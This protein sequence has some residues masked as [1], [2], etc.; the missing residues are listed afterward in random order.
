MRYVEFES[1]L[2]PT[3]GF[4]LV[5][6]N[7]PKTRHYVVRF[8]HREARAIIGHGSEFGFLP[9]AVMLLALLLSEPLN[10]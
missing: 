7:Y 10:R 6:L 1:S 4:A 9:V 8:G 5:R 2:K 3:L